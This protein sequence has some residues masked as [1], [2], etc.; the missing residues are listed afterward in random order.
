M[1]KVRQISPPHKKKIKKH[2]PLL[3]FFPKTRKIQNILFIPDAEKSGNVSKNQRRQHAHFQFCL[4]TW[5]SKFQAIAPL[6][7]AYG[8]VQVKRSDLANSPKTDE[9]RVHV[10][11]HWVCW[12]QQRAQYADQTDTQHPLA[13]YSLIRNI[14]CL[15]WIGR[16]PPATLFTW[17]RL[18]QS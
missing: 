17:P 1:G 3:L 16:V 9:S 6:L 2:N 4:P 14:F 12:H 5:L 7:R 18:C 11:R 13:Y 10:K 15:A 8:T